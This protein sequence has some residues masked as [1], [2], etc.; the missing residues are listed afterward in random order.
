MRDRRRSPRASAPLRVA[1]LRAEAAPAETR[2]DRIL[3]KCAKRPRARRQEIDCLPQ[4]RRVGIVAWDGLA[5]RQR[6][7][8]SLRLR[9]AQVR[10]E[11]NWFQRTIGSSVAESWDAKLFPEENRV[12]DT[13]RRNVP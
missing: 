2:C 5:R 9:H 1:K 8:F 7:E 12:A 4:A 10:D 13:R 11:A 6:F 3:S